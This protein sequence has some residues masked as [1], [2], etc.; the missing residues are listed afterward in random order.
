MAS[1]VINLA[2]LLLTAPCD[3]TQGR[4]HWWKFVERF[5]MGFYMC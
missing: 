1:A 2:G 4:F 3:I 5:C